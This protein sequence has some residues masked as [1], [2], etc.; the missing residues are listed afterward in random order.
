M[1]T[2]NKVVC[3]IIRNSLCHG[4]VEMNFKIENDELKE[5]IV[6][7]DSYHSK[8]RKLEITLEKLEKFLNS[9]AFLTKN[10]IIKE[11]ISKKI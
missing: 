5:F 4:N 2:F 1:K 9:E 8:I 11:E 10:C 7:E 6:F 3:E